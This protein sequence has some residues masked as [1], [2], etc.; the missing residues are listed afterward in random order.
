M[1]PRDARRRILDFVVEQLESELGP[2]LVRPMFGGFGLYSDDTFFGLIMKDVTYFRVDDGSRDRYV[3]RDAE[4]FEP[5]PDRPP[6][7]TYYAVPDDV[8]EDPTELVHWAHD[9]IAAARAKPK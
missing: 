1:G 7:R 5:F 8:L 4:P 6:S 9:A 2:V 3:A